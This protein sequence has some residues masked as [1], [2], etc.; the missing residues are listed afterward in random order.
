MAANRRS[1]DTYGCSRCQRTQCRAGGCCNPDM[2]WRLH[3]R[4]DAPCRARSQIR[5]TWP[6]RFRR[7]SSWRPRRRT[8]GRRRGF[9]QTRAKVEVEDSRAACY[10][11]LARPVVI[12]KAARGAAA[13]WVKS[14]TGVDR[15]H[16]LQAWRM[17]SEKRSSLERCA[18]ICVRRGARRVSRVLLRHSIEEGS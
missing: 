5:R 11:V 6:L 17:H 8:C 13:R 9:G 1:R 14:S 3:T 7:P 4:V 18:L 16:P 12:L 15:C 10:V 2:A